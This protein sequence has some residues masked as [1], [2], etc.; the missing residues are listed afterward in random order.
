[1][2]TTKAKKHNWCNGKA[3]LIK[4]EGEFKELTSCMVYSST[5]ILFGQAY[6][7]KHLEPGKLSNTGS[8]VFPHQRLYNTTPIYLTKQKKNLR[9]RSVDLE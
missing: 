1:M 7:S 4:G 3:G 5:C 8:K 9:K 2:K 6:I